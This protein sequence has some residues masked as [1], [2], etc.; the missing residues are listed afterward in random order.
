MN[1]GCTMSYQPYD[2]PL[3]YNLIN[4]Y[5]VIETDTN[6]FSYIKHLKD[7][8]LI[9]K[10]SKDFIKFINSRDV[11]EFIEITCPDKKENE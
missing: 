4:E 3:H 6:L 5:A 9:K 7:N 2:S 11:K 10:A 1:K 8:D